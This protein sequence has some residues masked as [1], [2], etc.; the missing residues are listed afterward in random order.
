MPAPLTWE[1]KTW[2][3]PCCSDRVRMGE[4]MVFR[5]APVLE[6]LLSFL[7]T[8]ELWKPAWNRWCKASIF[9]AS[10]HIADLR[11]RSQSLES[12]IG[13][14]S[15][16][17]G[18]PVRAIIIPLMILWLVT[19]PPASVACL[20]NRMRGLYE[21]SPPWA[22]HKTICDTA[23]FIVKGSARGSSMLLIDQTSLRASKFSCYLGKRAE[24]S[25]V[26]TQYF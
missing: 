10:S 21:K 23:R 6:N 4:G 9:K 8:G 20:S 16:D 14:K 25:L 5:K 11:E 18:P 26:C 17:L 24:I 13:K 15:H 22:I 19:S 2:K 7:W 12:S 1:T 3:A